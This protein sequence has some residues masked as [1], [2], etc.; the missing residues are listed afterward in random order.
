MI[1][2]NR[3]QK[4]EP[5]R[6]GALIFRQATGA[7][8]SALQQLLKDNPMQGWVTLSLQRSPSY[9]ASENL[10]GKSRTLIAYDRSCND[11]V[12]G[13]YRVVFMKTHIGGKPTLSGYLGELRVNRRY[14]H[15]M[16]VLRY[17]FESIRPLN[18]PESATTLNWFTSI[19]I[20]N[21]AARRLL[22][23]NN[24]KLPQYSPIGTLWTLAVS[25][26]RGVT[27]RLLQPATE[28]DI[29]PICQ[30]YNRAAAHYDFSPF[31]DPDWLRG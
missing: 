27:P 5:F 3:A 2:D 29:T 10:G 28:S 30:L 12:V 8:E 1:R 21:D 14:R 31:L 24:P 26:R 19:A 15:R 13:M 4:S 25:V 7:D 6:V 23:S 9:F 17:G 16:R 11:Q 22:E 20:D 18:V